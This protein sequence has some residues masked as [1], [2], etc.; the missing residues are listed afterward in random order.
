MSDEVP[1]AVN[2][3]TWPATPFI[4]RDGKVK[5]THAGFAGPDSGIFNAQLKE[6]FSN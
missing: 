5:A 4:G 3:K 1:Q 6:G 2:L